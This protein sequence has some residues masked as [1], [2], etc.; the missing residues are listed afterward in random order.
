MSGSRQTRTWALLFVTLVLALLWG[1]AFFAILGRG[2]AWLSARTQP[3]DIPGT[4]AIRPDLSGAL[5]VNLTAGELA[6]PDFSA[7]LAQLDA[8]GFRWV[9]LRLPWEKIEPQRGTYDWAATDAVFKA[10]AAHPALQPL[11]VLDG[12]PQWARP[13]ADAANPLAPPQT[14]GDFGKFVAA[15]AERYGRQVKYYQI[16]DEPNIAP[17]WGARPVDP[18]GYAGLLRE[19]SVQVRAADPGAQIVLA[20]LAPNI[21]S[22]GAN[23]SDLSYLAALYDAGARAWFDVVAAEPYGFSQSPDAPPSATA[24]NFGRAALLYQVMVRHGDAATALWATAFGW[25]APVTGGQG[26]ASPWGQVSEAQQAQFTSTALAQARTH[27]S[28]LGPLFWATDCPPAA[29]EGARQGFALCDAAG[30]ARPVWTALSTAASA[31]SAVLPPGEHAL[32]HPALHFTSGWRVRPSGADPS[33][34][35]DTLTFAFYGTSLAFRIQGGP[36]WAYDTIT[37][38]G[39]PADALPRDEHGA[40]YLVFDDP[41]SQTREVTVARRLPLGEH[42]VRVEANGGWDQWALQGILVSAA[43]LPLISLPV[44][45]VVALLATLVWLWLAWPWRRSAAVRLAAAQEWAER[46]PA[47]V[48][49]GLTAVLGL[50]FLFAPRQLLDL[51]LLLGLGVLALLRPVLVLPVAAAAIPFWPQTKPFLRWQFNAFELLVWLSTAVALLR[52]ALAPANPLAPVSAAEPLPIASLAAARAAQAMAGVRPPGWS[53][54][55]TPGF[56][57]AADLRAAE[58][59]IAR[60]ALHAP[61]S[62]EPDGHP[63]AIGGARAWLSAAGAQL[64]LAG[65]DWIVL[66]LLA[67]GL[68]STLAALHT[69]VA[70]REYR[71]VFVDAGLFYFLVTRGLAALRSEQPRP[72]RTAWGRP[73]RPFGTAGALLITDGLL[74]GLVLVSLIGLWQLATG[75][76]RIDVEGVWRVRGLYGSPNN[77]ALVLD[78]GVPIALAIA[79]FGQ[80]GTVRRWCYGIAAAVMAVA[81]VATFSKGALLLGLPAG[82]G[83]VVIGGAWRARSRWPLVVL[84]AGS[85]A[86][87][88]A[89]VL[90]FRTQRF[91][92]LTNFQAGTS[93]IRIKLWQSALHMAQDHPWLGVGPDNFLYAYRTR[94]VLPSAWEELNLSHPHN[95]VLDLWTRLGLIGLLAGIWS[96]AAAFGSAWRGMRHG[97]ALAWPLSLGLLGALAAT[98]LHGLIDNSLFLIDLMAIFMM[99]LALLESMRE[100]PAIKY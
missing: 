57:S 44:L 37:V 39:R 26:P 14:R 31:S 19:A 62:V 7:R 68:A 2:P 72:E 91:A 18:V 10:L 29:G 33:A 52:R 54:R 50:G 99:S 46:W 100:T 11:V 40:A 27:W 13:T 81:C 66:A 64:G 75:Q 45:I 56:F 79:F 85:V 55:R 60:P 74:A 20:A 38:D 97:S 67:A 24:L 5:G 89:M 70:W 73:G 86:V 77:L 41:L 94:Y 8:A 4:P 16:W 96:L 51:P 17:H 82:I 48:A 25:S 36:F 47:P 71:M 6:A 28:W 87:G 42:Q 83:V 98:V 90:L 76:G 78:R 84:A 23:Q 63:A 15:V 49:W 53:W 58:P 1:S 9:R 69:D 35:G 88:L 22:G 43:Q 3:G 95:I 93:F 12:S 80:T 21:E 65:M 59:S 30:G 61:A 34:N 32:D 92:D